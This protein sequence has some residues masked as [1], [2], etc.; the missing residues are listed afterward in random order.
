M[1]ASLLKAYVD[2]LA[3][4]LR[5]DEG[6]PEAHFAADQL[7]RASQLLEF[8]GAQDAAEFYARVEANEDWAREAE[9]RRG[10]QEGRAALMHELS[11]GH[12]LTH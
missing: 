1:N 10:V 2:I 11:N 7:E 12:H 3:R 5:E 9:F 6:T 4:R 8:T